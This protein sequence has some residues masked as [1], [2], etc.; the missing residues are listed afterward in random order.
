LIAEYRYASGLK[1]G[2][3]VLA[4]G[5]VKNAVKVL[6]WTLYVPITVSFFNGVGLSTNLQRSVLSERI[7]MLYAFLAS[8]SIPPKGRGAGEG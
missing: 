8:G 5:E 7:R 6:G 1:D 3:S 2:L 4:L